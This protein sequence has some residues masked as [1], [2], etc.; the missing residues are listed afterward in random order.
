MTTRKFG[1]RWWRQIS[2][3]EI[4]PGN[5]VCFVGRNYAEYWRKVKSVTHKGKIRTE[6]VKYMGTIAVPSKSIVPADIV[7]AWAKGIG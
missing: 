1:H 5:I 6:A 4:K 7:S 3:K 2:I